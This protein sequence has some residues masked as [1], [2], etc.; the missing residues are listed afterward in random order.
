MKKKCRGAV[1][2]MHRKHIAA[3]N[4]SRPEFSRQVSGPTCMPLQ[5]QPDQQSQQCHLQIAKAARMLLM[6]LGEDFAPSEA[7]FDTDAHDAVALRPLASG[8]PVPAVK[9]KDAAVPAPPLL[10]LPLK[11]AAGKYRGDFYC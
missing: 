6:L 1:I 7:N 10:P 5:S 3:F 9:V 8:F 4:Q 11:N 2:D